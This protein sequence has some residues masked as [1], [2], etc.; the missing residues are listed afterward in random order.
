[1]RSYLMQSQLDVYRDYLPTTRQIAVVCGLLLVLVLTSS[2]SS[3][4][5]GQSDETDTIVDQTIQA[6]NGATTEEPTTPAAQ[7]EPTPAA[8][9][10][11]APAPAV[12]PATPPGPATPAPAVT[13]ESDL[14][15]TGPAET[16]SVTIGV[17]ALIFGY[18]H[19]RQSRARLNSALTNS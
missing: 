3:T 16:A 17:I 11:P 9:P 19:Y 15:T 14:P 10:T 2:I 12:E 6:V 8:T 18:R 1:M 4:T 13:S 5:F 7:E